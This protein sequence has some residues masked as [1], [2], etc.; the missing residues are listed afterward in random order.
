M[1]QEKEIISRAEDNLKRLLE[2]GSRYDSKSSFVTSVC[3]AMLGT[4][5]G[6]LPAFS[7]WTPILAVSFALSA[8][9][10]LISLIM[11]YSAQYPK[12]K[13]PNNSLIFWG[14]I[15]NIYQ[16]DFQKNFRTMSDDEYLT[17]VLH[18]SK[19]NAD[20]VDQKFRALKRALLLLL[21][22]VLPWLISLYLSKIGMS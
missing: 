4:L 13:S 7:D 22:S 12:T 1:S 11:I 16:D 20:V 14:T 17:D 9:L 8:G 3:I 6:F 15:A 5:V 19:I 10:L 18:Q 21:L 2:W